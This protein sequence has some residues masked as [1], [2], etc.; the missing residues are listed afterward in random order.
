M[1]QQACSED[2]EGTVSGKHVTADL[3]SEILNYV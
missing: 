3:I 2:K 1:L